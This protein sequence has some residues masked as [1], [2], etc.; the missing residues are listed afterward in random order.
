[1][2]TELGSS[3]TNAGASGPPTNNDE[4][5]PVDVGLDVDAATAFC[6]VGATEAGDVHHAALV[7]IHHTG[8]EG[9][10]REVWLRL[11]QVGPGW[12]LQAPAVPGPPLPSCSLT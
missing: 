4:D 11:A 10:E 2:S 9:R 12:G 3:G 1:M 5:L 8:C 7:D 6:V